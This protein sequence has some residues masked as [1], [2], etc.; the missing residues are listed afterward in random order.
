MATK[1]YREWDSTYERHYFV[2]SDGRSQW[3]APPGAE[4]ACGGDFLEER[5]EAAASSA[6]HRSPHSSEEEGEEDVGAEEASADDDEGAAILSESRDAQRYQRVHDETEPFMRCY[7][8][9][10]FGHSFLCEAPLAV[11]EGLV[12]AAGS[13]AAAAALAPLNRPRARLYLREAALFGAGALTL[14]VPCAIQ[15][16]YADFSTDNDAWDLRPLP[17][18][19]G[20]VDPRR[21]CVLS[22]G[23]GAAARNA[24]DFRGPSLDSPWEGAVLHPPVAAA[25]R[26]ARICPPLRNCLLGDDLDAADARGLTEMPLTSTFLR[27]PTS[28]TTQAAKKMTELTATSR[29]PPPH[30]PR[31]AAAKTDV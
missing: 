24:R 11:A 2:A 16:A 14:A 7:T 25:Q 18:V 10:F 5:T 28:S 27:Q 29:G 30:L 22:L 13:L 31:T 20:W 9:C 8:A 23:Q 12:R 6:R 4:W 26:V 21:F 3:E 15:A 17:T 1:W 19:C